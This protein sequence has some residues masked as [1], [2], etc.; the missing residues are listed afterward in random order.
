MSAIFYVKTISYFHG[1]IYFGQHKDDR[2][3]ASL[4]VDMIWG[5]VFSSTAP[6]VGG[7]V[8]GALSS[9]AW[10]FLI[11]GGGVDAKSFWKEY[12]LQRPGYR[13]S[14]GWV[15]INLNHAGLLLTEK[16]IMIF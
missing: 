11:S 1:K 3:F 2:V 4:A 7:D 15:T 8:T 16:C 14:Y 9:I 5:L 10:S 6:W 13:S 12:F